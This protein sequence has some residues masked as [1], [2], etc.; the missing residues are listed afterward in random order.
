V[1]KLVDEPLLRA[2]FAY[3]DELRLHFGQAVPYESGR[4][5]GRTRGEWGL[6]LRATPWVLARDSTI[7]SRS[8]DE[9]QHA[10]RQFEEREGKRVTATR[11]RR[12]DAAVTLRF[13]DDSWFIALTETRPEDETLDLWE[14]LTP[15]GLV[16][17]A[18][19]D[20][21]VTIEAR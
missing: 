10:L 9:P 12:S 6:S 13:E 3:G 18:R 1:G 11:F 20:A 21:S 14:L 5:L 2:S 8:T 16:V 4:M 19:P 7:L 17:V 15:H